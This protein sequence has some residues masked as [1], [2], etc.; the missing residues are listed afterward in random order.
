MINVH[1][2]LHSL[3]KA[4]GWDV[5]PVDICFFLWP[6]LPGWCITST[7]SNRLEKTSDQRG[8]GEPFYSLPYINVLKHLKKKYLYTIDTYA[9]FPLEGFSC[10]GWSRFTVSL[11]TAAARLVYT[12]SLSHNYRVSVLS[13]LSDSVFLMLPRH[14]SSSSSSNIVL[15]RSSSCLK[16]F[17]QFRVSLNVSNLTYIAQRHY[18]LYFSFY[19]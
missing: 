16:T 4:A 3:N 9:N 15:T 5:N 7:D 18:L 8:A 17:V 12:F 13:S 11:I 1:I 2:S 10:K 19:L 14:S 6:I